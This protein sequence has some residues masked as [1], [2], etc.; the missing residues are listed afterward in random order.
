MSLGLFKMLFIYKTYKTG[1]G[2]KWPTTV[3]MP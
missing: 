2:I 1:F 3:D